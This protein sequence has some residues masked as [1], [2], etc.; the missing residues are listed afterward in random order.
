MPEDTIR[1]PAAGFSVTVVI[2]LI[3]YP[4]SFSLWLPPVPFSVHPV[5]GFD[6]LSCL[7]DI[8]HPL[9]HVNQQIE[10]WFLMHLGTLFL[11]SIM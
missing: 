7:Q 6:I 9:L 3:R 1:H 11:F 2:T 8:L 4:G 10:A 5:E